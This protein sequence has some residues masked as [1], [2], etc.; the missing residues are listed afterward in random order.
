MWYPYLSSRICH[1]V[2]VSGAEEAE[3]AEADAVGVLLH[4]ARLPHTQGARQGPLMRASGER[5]EGGG[6]GEG[7]G[8]GGAGSGREWVGAA[9][10]VRAAQGEL[11]DA[12]Q[13][14][15]RGGGDICQA[16]KTERVRFKRQRGV[17]YEMRR[18]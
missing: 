15:C 3:L 14:V 11:L 4:A 12:A 17:R 2:P 16:Q 6:A 1:H 10:A 5:E 8:L 13:C 18:L 9:G 7:P